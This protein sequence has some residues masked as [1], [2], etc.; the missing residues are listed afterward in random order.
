MRAKGITWVAVVLS[1][2]ASSGCAGGAAAPKAAIVDCDRIAG[3]ARTFYESNPAY[4]DPRGDDVN[5]SP[6]S[7]EEQGID[8]T[9]LRAGLTALGDDPSMFGVLVIR[10]GHLVAER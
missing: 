4:T 7:P 10:H 5:L 8:S 2:L 1:L 3:D 9:L 6:T